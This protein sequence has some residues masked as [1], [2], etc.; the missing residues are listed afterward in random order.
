MEAKVV[1]KIS[2]YVLNKKKTDKTR[3]LQKNFI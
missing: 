3:F 2:R 1:K